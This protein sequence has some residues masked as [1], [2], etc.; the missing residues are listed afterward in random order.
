MTKKVLKKGNKSLLFREKSL[1]L[2][3]DFVGLCG[4]MFLKCCLTDQKQII[5]Y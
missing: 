3:T 1:S 2:Q 5:K 4:K